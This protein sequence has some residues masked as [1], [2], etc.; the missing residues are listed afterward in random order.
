[1]RK[2]L[3]LVIFS[4]LLL[5]GCSTKEELICDMGST[6]VTI[7]LNKGKIINYVDKIDGQLSKEEID[8]LNESYLKEI[9]N[10]SEAINKL[11]DVIAIA[12]GICN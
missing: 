1:M 2:I 6:K 12:G 9:N 3:L 5:T 11:K 8:L 10:N 7:T 4:S